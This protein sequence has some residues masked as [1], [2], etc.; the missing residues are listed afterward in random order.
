MKPNSRNN[1]L[2]SAEAPKCSRET[3]CPASP[4]NLYQPCAMPASTTTRAR[5]DGGSTLS[6]YSWGWDSNHSTQGNDTT[7][8][9]IPLAARIFLA[10]TA[11]CSSEPVPM[12]ITS[13]ASAGLSL[14]ASST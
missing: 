1:V 5:T 4:T 3:I 6:R 8:A 2:S 12:R 11:S 13:G 7:E 14:A 10:S 9:A